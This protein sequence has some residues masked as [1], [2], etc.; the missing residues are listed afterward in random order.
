MANF[1]TADTAIEPPN[2]TQ[3]AQQP[4]VPLDCA[5]DAAC[6]VY[7]LAVYISHHQSLTDLINNGASTTYLQAKAFPWVTAATV[8]THGHT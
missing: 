8:S 2:V 6:A 1:A 4:P 5:N 3:G 7:F